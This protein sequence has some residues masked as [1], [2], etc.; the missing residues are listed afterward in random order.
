MRMDPAGR[1]NRWNTFQQRLG[2]LR[3]DFYVISWHATRRNPNANVPTANVLAQLQPWH[4]EMNTTR[5][6]TPGLLVPEL[7][8]DGGRVP[9]PVYEESRGFGREFQRRQGP[10]AG[11]AQTGRKRARKPKSQEAQ[12]DR[13]SSGSPDSGAADTNED[14]DEEE[15]QPPPRKTRR[16]LPAPET[17]MPPTSPNLAPALYQ[18]PTLPSS[19]LASTSRDSAGHGG[20]NEGLVYTQQAPWVYNQQASLV[21]TQLFSSVY[22]QQPMA[23]TPNPYQQYG[24]DNPG[25]RLA[26]YPPGFVGGPSPL[27]QLSTTQLLGRSSTDAT[28]MVHYSGIGHSDRQTPYHPFTRMDVRNTQHF[29]PP[30]APHLSA[31]PAPY[32]VPPPPPA[33]GNNNNNNNNNNRLEE[34][35]RLR[36]FRLPGP[37]PTLTEAETREN[38]AARGRGR[39]NGMPRYVDPLL[40]R[41]FSQYTSSFRSGSLG[42]LCSRLEY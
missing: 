9:L 35:P 1:P 21:N 38:A 15:Q 26:P 33:T 25:P 12:A 42:T 11:P 40:E 14:E 13:L 36:H 10:N 7:G 5:G 29:R 19:H 2:R 23:M 39:G 37:S 8:E 32:T 4:F 20:Q 17:T 31:G 41:F 22:T 28:N 24:H 34:E 16:L 6:L 18:T 30:L 27:R 3:P